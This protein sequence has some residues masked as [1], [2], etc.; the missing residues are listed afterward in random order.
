MLSEHFF[1]FT[2]NNTSQVVQVPP[3]GAAAEGSGS[4]AL[5]TEYNETC[6]IE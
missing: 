2:P 4:I 3:H 6:F 5:H 1:K